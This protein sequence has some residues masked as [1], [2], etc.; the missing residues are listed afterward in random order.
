M[1]R[2]IMLI[3]GAWLTPACWDLF[4]A[5]YEAK[6]YNIVAPPWPLENVPIEELRT[7]PD[8][9]LRKMTVKKIVDHYARLIKSLPEKPILI[10]HSY[11]GLFVQLLLDR[12]LGAAGIALDPVP[13]AGVLPPPRVLLS[14][15]PVF[16]VLFGWNRV[17][18]QSFKTFSTTF[19]QTLPESEKRKTYE[20][21]WAPT[22]GRLYYQ[23]ALGLETGIKKGNP[24]R[25]PLLLVCGQSDITITPAC[26][27]AVY[28]I[29]KHSPSATDF[30]TFPGRSH[31]LF[32]EPGWQE[33]ADFILDWALVH[34]KTVP[35][36]LRRSA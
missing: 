36:P 7:H 10:G 31:Y 17:L 8:P 15:W 34:T 9:D 13:I 33:V 11:G 35:V 14:A 4:R 12:G 20:T 30:H 1:S 32:H 21:Y 6:G 18:I 2:T 22:P 29:Q 3:H 23:G 5:H 19:A 28:N 26:V 25:P 16:S 27:R 24:R